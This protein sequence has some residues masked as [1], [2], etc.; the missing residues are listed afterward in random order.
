M[1]NEVQA[2]VDSFIAD[3][4][5][6]ARKATLI[7]E[8]RRLL[9]EAHADLRRVHAEDRKWEA[10]AEKAREEASALRA[11]LLRV[12]KEREEALVK[13]ASTKAT[14]KENE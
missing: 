10:E 5:E 11:E 3:V 7:K 9:N 14:T 13:A 4:E 12:K 2:A 8:L 6:S 1:T